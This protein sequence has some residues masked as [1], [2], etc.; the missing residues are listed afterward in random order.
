MKIPEFLYGTYRE[1]KKK[2]NKIM[3]ELT[4]EASWEE[5]IESFPLLDTNDMDGNLIMGPYPGEKDKNHF[6]MY[7]FLSLLGENESLENRQEEIFYKHL[8]TPWGTLSMMPRANGLMTFYVIPSERHIPFLKS[9]SKFWAIFISEENIFTRFGEIRPLWSYNT[10]LL[11]VLARRGIPNEIL[12]GPL[13]N[14][15][16]EAFLKKY[17]FPD[18]PLL[19]RFKNS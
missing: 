1:V 3:R 17:N 4:K 10:N 5:A 19:E 2:S 11:F 7:S 8:E 12:R 18:M 9:V 14:N 6:Q 15:D 13:P 16:L